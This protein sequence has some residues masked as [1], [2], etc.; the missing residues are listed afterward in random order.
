MSGFDEKYIAERITE[1]RLKKDI[2]EYKMSLDLGKNKSYI[3]SIC[4]GRNLPK[5]RQFFDICE[6]LEVTPYEFYDQNLHNVPLYQ[7]A[8]DLLK[9]LDEEDLLAVISILNRLTAKHK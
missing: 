5:M 9:Q 2:S 8:N 4:S 3:Q 1:L 7:K 6:Y